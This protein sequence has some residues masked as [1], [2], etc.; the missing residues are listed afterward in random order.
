MKPKNNE[1]Y[2]YDLEMLSLK[3]FPSRRTFINIT[4]RSIVRRSGL[5]SKRE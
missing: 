3:T 1:K 4:K 2:R 5:M